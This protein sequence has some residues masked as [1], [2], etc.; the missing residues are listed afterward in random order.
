MP[1]TPIRGW[2]YYASMS[3]IALICFTTF[4]VAG[5]LHYPVVAG[6]MLMNT[7]YMVFFM[8][9][10]QAADKRKLK[11]QQELEKERL[12]HRQYVETHSN[13]EPNEK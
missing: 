9:D 12:S 4:L 11:F 2:G 8:I 10:A 6:A 13:K 7:M 5:F 3:L 1:M